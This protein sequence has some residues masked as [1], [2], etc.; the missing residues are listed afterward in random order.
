MVKKVSRPKRSYGGCSVHHFSPKGSNGHP[1]PINIYI[2]FEEAIKLNLA[3][4]AGLLS[5]NRL[6]RRKARGAGINLYVRTKDPPGITV[7][8]ANL[9]STPG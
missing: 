4:Q 9:D 8:A 7:N 2:K 5:I 3:I 1:N 6:D